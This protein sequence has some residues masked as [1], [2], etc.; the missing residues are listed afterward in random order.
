MCTLMIAPENVRP[1]GSGLTGAPFK[2]LVFQLVS[3]THG[4]ERYQEVEMEKEGLSD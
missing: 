1:E 3:L 2:R 4:T